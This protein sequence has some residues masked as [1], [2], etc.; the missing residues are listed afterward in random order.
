MRVGVQ[1]VFQSYG[2]G[3]EVSDGQVVAEEVRLGVLADELGLD[4]TPELS[5][6]QARILNHDPDLAAPASAWTPPAGDVLRV[7]SSSGS[8]EVKAFVFPGIHPDCIAI[9]L[10]QGHTEYGRYAKGVG[11]NPYRI[12][13]P[14]FDAKTGELATFATDVQVA[15]VADRGPIVTLA[16][17]KLVLENGSNSQAG[18]ELVKTVT[19][20]QFNRTEEA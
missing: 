20:K 10:G 13:D 16:H 1:M 15:K 17:G 11:V 3:P 2:Y 8:V 4:P 9:P 5:D 6:L 12:L 14:K 18:R 19:A 7:T